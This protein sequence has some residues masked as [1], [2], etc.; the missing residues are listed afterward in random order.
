M[1][2]ST[3]PSHSFWRSDILKSMGRFLYSL[4]KSL[5][6]TVFPPCRL[7]KRLLRAVAQPRAG[8]RRDIGGAGDAP[9]ALTFH[10]SNY[11]FIQLFEMQAPGF[12]W[13][14]HGRHD[15]AV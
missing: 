3:R 13:T 8:G 12:A 6:G 10:P 9:N 15:N 2:D 14:L 4:L 7:R 5:D 1:K 11:S